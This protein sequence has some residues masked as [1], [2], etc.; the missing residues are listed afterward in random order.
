MCTPES[1]DV[2]RVAWLFSL[3]RCGSSVTAYASAAP[4]DAP[5]ADEMDDAMDYAAETAESEATWE[6]EASVDD[7]M[8][9]TGYDDGV[10]AAVE[11]PPTATQLVSV[12]TQT[13]AGG[14]LV[15]LD[16]DGSVGALAAQNNRTPLQSWA[17]C[18]TSC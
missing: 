8:A 14:V 9:A 1:D 4:W 5:V 10:M 15:G 11:A 12:S 2:T 3:A 17:S 6:D 7:S 13:T 16:T 18:C